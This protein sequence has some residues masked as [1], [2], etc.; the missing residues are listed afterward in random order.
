MGRDAL[1]VRLKQGDVLPIDE[2][3]I[4]LMNDESVLAE[5]DELAIHATPSGRTRDEVR[6]NAIPALAIQRAVFEH[7]TACGYEVQAPPP[8]T[9]QYDGIVNGILVD[10]K[11]RLDGK[12]WQQTLWEKRTL[13]QT[14]ERVL[15]LCVDVLPNGKYIF[16]GAVWIENLIPSP[17]GCPYVSHRTFEDFDP[18]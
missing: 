15:Y 9:F 17:Y 6:A 5:A 11:A 13:E 14:G 7:M 4:A 2:R 12:F 8:N 10:V 16:K 3:V 18:T 1:L